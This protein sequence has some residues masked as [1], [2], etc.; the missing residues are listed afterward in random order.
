[1]TRAITTSRGQILIREA[2]LADA[3]RFRELRLEAL[4]DSPTAFSADYQTNARQP[5]S[6]WQDRLKEEE[7]AI[8]FFAEHEQRLIGM[9]GIR[10]GHSPKTNHGAEIW[11]VYITP[12]WRGLHLSEA[13]IDTCVQW[14]KS[15]D[16]NILKLGV[17]T[18]NTSAV[19]CYQRC[20][21]AIYGTE[22]R[23]IFYDGQ[24]YDGYLM[25]RS[26]DSS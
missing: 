20:G 1:M 26:L 4:Q 14:A 11:G 13:L 21:F 24:Y 16:I 8:I 12:E 19:R 22:P 3:I 2:S 18:A 7:D 5:L 10:R 17:L 15:K 23:G 9:M 6:Y 25:Y